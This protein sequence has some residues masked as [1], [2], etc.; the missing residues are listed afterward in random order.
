MNL[1]AREIPGHV[2]QHGELVFS[3]DN[4]QAA[5]DA[6]RASAWAECREAAANIVEDMLR[7]TSH[8]WRHVIAAI[9]ALEP[10]HE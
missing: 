7:A 5:L 1:R 6:A 9:R 4:V 10:P 3:E 2:D 8:D